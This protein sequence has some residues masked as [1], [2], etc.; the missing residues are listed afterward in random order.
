MVLPGDPYMAPSAAQPVRRRLIRRSAGPTPNLNRVRKRF[1]RAPGVVDPLTPLPMRK[2]SE[3]E[4]EMSAVSKISWQRRQ[5]AVAHAA[6]N[7]RK[8]MCA[9]VQC[10]TQ[11]HSPYTATETAEILSPSPD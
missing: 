11:A 6:L 7:A 5:Y 10:T 3:T 8:A 1:R 2:P 9:Q 4:A